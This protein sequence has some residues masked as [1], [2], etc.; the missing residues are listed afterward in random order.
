[1]FICISIFFSS[2]QNT[3]NLNV[4]RLLLLLLLSFRMSH[5]I[6]LVAFEFIH[7]RWVSV[8]N[9]KLDFLIEIEMVFYLRSSCQRIDLVQRINIHPEILKWNTECDN[10]K[11]DGFF[12]LYHWLLLCT[13]S[14]AGL[15]CFSFRYCIESHH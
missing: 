13:A 10:N 9:E 3:I 1:M 2:L 6:C 8:P 7:S 4:I 12:Q 15:K 11:T 14:V 5:F